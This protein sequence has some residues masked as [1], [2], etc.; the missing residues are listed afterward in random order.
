MGTLSTVSNQD[1]EL[2]YAAAQE[3]LARYTHMRGR[4][5]DTWL[6]LVMAAAA[7]WNEL[8]E[9]LAGEPPPFYVGTPI[10]HKDI[11]RRWEGSSLYRPVTYVRYLVDVAARAGK[12]QLTV[13]EVPPQLAFDRVDHVPRDTKWWDAAEFVSPER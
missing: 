6:K 8:Q 12:W 10:R 3:R 9:R 13:Y 1:L 2:A 7:V 5:T 4:D 11:S